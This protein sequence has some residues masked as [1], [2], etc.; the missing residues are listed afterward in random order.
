MTAGRRRLA[1]A[2]CIAALGLA[3]LTA[4]G[5]QAQLEVLMETGLVGKVEGPRL[6]EDRA[7]WPSSFAEA[8]MLAE[9]VAGG[10]LPPVAERLPKDLAVWE[11]VHEIGRYGGTWR[12]GFT[13]P[14]D[15]ENGNRINASDQL[16]LWDETGAFPV[17]S[18]VKGLEVN[19]DMTE[20]RL[21]LREGLRWSDGHPFTADDFL[22][23]Y[24]D[25]YQNPDIVTEQLSELAVGGQ[26]G[27]M[28]MVDDFTVA[29][30][31]DQPY[32]L[33]ADTLAGNSQIDGGQSLRQFQG[34]S[35]GGYAPRHYLAQFLPKYTPVEELEAAARAEGFDSWV[36]RFHAKKD[37]LSNLELPTV[38]P[39]RTVQP[40]NTPTW[41]LERN[42]YYWAVDT[43]GN[44]LP[45][46]DRI[47]MS[48]V[49][50]F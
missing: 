24:E 48:L 37:W 34:R 4:G 45:Y 20:F 13:G 16:F 19:D 27:R 15:A 43:A 10:E 32:P 2:A 46:I 44:Q 22:F 25:I 29:F 6:I 5:A 36:A 47:V 49:D 33:F 39:W 3:A 28:E 1:T 35:T 30:R 7:R 23:W 18:L 9:R 8:P 31:F 38:G 50:C 40:I 42:P 21:L 11:P 17:P 12:R 14:G 41:V 26:P